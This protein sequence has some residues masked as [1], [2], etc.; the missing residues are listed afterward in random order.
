MFSAFAG[1]G[2]LIGFVLFYVLPFLPFLYFFFAV[3]NW[4]KGIFEAVV[5]MPLW[6]LAHLRIDGEG[7]PGEAAIG[8]YFLIFEIFIRP[9]LIV[10]G[11]LAAVTVFAAMVKVMNEVFYLLI[12]NVSGSDPRSSAACFTNP[13][14]TAGQQDVIDASRVSLSNAYRG[15]VDEFFFTIVYTILV[16]MIGT[17]CFKMIDMLPNEM[18]RW[19]NAEIPAFNDSTKD[20][21]EGLMKYVTM[22]GA[23]FGSQI[24]DSV[25]G[26]GGGVKESVLQFTRGGR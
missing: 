21:A 26:I 19:I 1:V 17:T 12:S 20:S 22:G 7:I 23:K 24:G 14:A 8:G 15:P 13:N 18:L 9:I 2:L 16:Y 11:L 5:A 10:F 4:V 6:A 3:G 25:A